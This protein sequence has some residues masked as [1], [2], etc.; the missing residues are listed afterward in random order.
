MRA[1]KKLTRLVGWYATVTQ[2]SIAPPAL[3]RRATTII[4]LYDHYFGALGMSDTAL[5]RDD[6]RLAFAPGQRDLPH[7]IRWICHAL[8]IA[9]VLWITWSLTFVIYYWSDKAQVLRNYGQLFSADLSN[10]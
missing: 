3:P 4:K 9:A 10:V 5:H 1:P 6:P 2:T 7:R 8:R